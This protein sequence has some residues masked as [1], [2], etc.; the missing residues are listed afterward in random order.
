MGLPRFVVYKGR[1]Y[2]LQ[3]TGRYYSDGDHNAPERLLHRVIWTEHFGRIPKGFCVH[4]KNGNW[5]DDRPS[6]LELMPLGAHMSHHLRERFKDQK[7]RRNNAKQLAD[8]R[9]GAS[10]WHKSS[11]GRKWHSVNSKRAWADG[12]ITK[13]L[14]ICTECGTPFESFH[15]NRG[16]VH[17]CSERCQGKRHWRIYHDLMTRC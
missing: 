11:Q 17:V 1:K 16:S 14:A 15:H 4:H 10:L 6:N 13:G 3:S 12:K 9:M 2:W 5:R 7:Y 8:A